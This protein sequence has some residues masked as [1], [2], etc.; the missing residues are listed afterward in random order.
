M[1]TS[2]NEVINELGAQQLGL[3]TRAQLL[4]AGLTGETIKARVRAQWLR[5]LHRGVYHVGPVVV[6]RAR[7]LAAVLACGR[8]AVLSH[9]SAAALWGLV[10]DPGDSAPIDITTTRDCGHRPGIRA[11]R[12]AALRPDEIAR[13][14]S[15]PVTTPTRTLLDVA[16]V[17]ALRDFEQALA[18]AERDELVRREGLLSVLTRNRGRIGTPVLRAVLDGGGSPTLT[19][20]QA[21]ERFLELVRRAQLPAPA[22]NATIGNV[23]VD[24]HWRKERLV[25]EVD[26][27]AFHASKRRF[28][29][30]R[31]RDAALLARGL[32]I[33]RVTWH[34]IVDEPEAVLVR[35]AQALTH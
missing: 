17:L 6:P 18:R 29:G 1:A 15:I 34:Q 19:R 16:S 32:R 11:H 7:A 4:E 22:S 30:D 27:Y 21:E 10:P 28:E 8:N 5:R 35:L 2:A 3:V 33:M 20:S 25:V 13:A 9:L 14:H 23:E 12:R 26:G 24:F 31:R